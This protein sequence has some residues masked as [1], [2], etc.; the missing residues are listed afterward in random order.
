M[1]SS[2]PVRRA[3]A[4]LVLLALATACSD[5]TPTAPSGPPD[6]TGS[7][8]SGDRRLR[9]D[10]VQSGPSVQGTVVYLDG[11]APPAPIVPEITSER[12]G[13]RVVTPRSWRPFSTRR[14]WSS[15][16]GASRRRWPE[17]G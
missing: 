13:F 17:I 4:A 11:T 9:L 5:Q 15:T 6:L 10:L 12:F 3:A 14:R 7:W 16:V 2:S 1:L 8:F